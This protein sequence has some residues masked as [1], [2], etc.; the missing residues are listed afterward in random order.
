MNL[1]TLEMLTQTIEK[2][3]KD[4]ITIEKSSKDPNNWKK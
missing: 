1:L 2:S 4:L 3:S